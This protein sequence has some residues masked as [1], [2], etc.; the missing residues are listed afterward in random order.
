MLYG[1]DAAVAHPEEAVRGAHRFSSFREV[2]SRL[3]AG[4]APSSP[5]P[6]DRDADRLQLPRRAV[7]SSV[8]TRIPKSPLQSGTTTAEYRSHTDGT[9]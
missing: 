4:M 1:R 8:S 2:R 9:S 5:A 7:A 3:R 6:L